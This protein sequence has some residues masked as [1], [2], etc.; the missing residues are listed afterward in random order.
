MKS[1]TLK[2]VMNGV[3]GRMGRHQHLE[4]SILAI[5][6]Q[7]GIVIGNEQRVIPEPILLGR[8]EAKLRILAKNYNIEHYSTDLDNCL[9]DPEVD[10]YFDAQITSER[11]KSVLKA[12]EAGKNIYCEKPSAE[13]LEH[14]I[15]LHERA[16]A[17]GIK[18][19]VVQDKLFLPGLLKLQQLIRTG[20][21]G[22]ILSVRGEFGYWVF[23]G[24]DQECQRPSWNYRKESGGGII[25]DMFAHWRYLIDNLFGKIESLTC[26]GA[27][28]IQ[29]RK[30]EQQVEYDCNAEDAAYAI[31]LC[32]GGIVCQFNSSWA[33]RVRR[34]DLLTIQV[35]GTQASAVVGLRDC[36]LQHTSY[37]PKPVWNPDIAS[38]IDYSANWQKMPAN[39]EYV[40]AFR[41]QWERFLQ[42]MV[43]DVDFSWNLQEGAKGV[44]LGVLAQQSWRDRSWVQVP[45]I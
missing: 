11:H 5:R 7:G 3:T 1:R 33:V 40:N 23:D 44:Q 31:F 10:I 39:F 13:K 36:W 35:D 4:R 25:L 45:D 34:D 30:D 9:S 42:H 41:L 2:I 21:F 28:H 22:R 12:I 20:Y 29:K 16:E 37:T 8:N 27:T 32:H 19:G 26:V 15:E 18:H 17:V 6:D 24:F 43:T 14:A 38:K